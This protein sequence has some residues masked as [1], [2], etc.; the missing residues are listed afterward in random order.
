MLIHRSHLFRS[1]SPLDKKRSNDSKPNVERWVV[2]ESSRALTLPQKNVLAKGLNFA[3][4]PKVIPIPE[5]VAAVEDGLRKADK[6]KASLARVGI[7]GILNKA[8]PPPS[9]LKPDELKAIKELRND[10]SVM[11]LPADKGRATVLL[12]KSQYDLKV[13]TMLS[14]PTTYKKLDRDPVKRIERKLNEILMSLKKS[15]SIPPGLYYKLRSS[16]G[17]TPLF[18]GLPKIHKPGIP[19][20][21]IVSFINSPTYQLSK[22]LVKIISPLVGKTDSHV[23]NSKDFSSFIVEQHLPQET[24]LVSFDVVSLFTSVPVKR[25][26]E[27]AYQR[28]IDD[29]TLEERTILTA[30]EIVRLLEFCLNATYLTYCGEVYQQVFGTAMGSP[31]SVTVANLIMEDIEQRALSTFHSPPSFWKRYVDDV[32]TA[33]PED[34]VLSF[35]EHLNTIEDSI[36]FTFEMEEDHQLAFLDTNITHHSDGSF[37]TSVYRKKTHTDKYLSFDSHHPL[38]H[39][40][41]VA[42][43]LFIRANNIC[44]SPH[45]QKKEKNHIVD[46]LRTNGYPSSVIKMNYSV[47]TSVKSSDNNEPIGTVVLPYIRHVSESIKRILTPLNIRTCFR[48]HQTLKTILVHAKDKVPMSEKRGIVYQIP[49]GSC[50]HT[51]IGQ[52]GRTLEDRLKEHKRAIIPDSTYFTSAVAEHAVKSNHVIDWNNAKVIDSH[53]NLYQRCYLESW[54]IKKRNSSMNRDEGLLPTVYNCLIHNSNYS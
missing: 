11:I 23:K 46:A 6:G 18:Y 48:P 16:A 50:N 8:R 10:N 30:Q 17:K 20:R 42:K 13:R 38:A 19:L 7:I 1:A 44:T 39:K 36:K 2:N 14:N 43:T 40:V 47:S 35:H 52:S 21:P 9:N 32:F 25:A 28:L 26:T 29:S 27:I 12:D 4:S 22:H 49:C 54:Q 53:S 37:S 5:I 24:K 45:D 31:V 3:P 15:G 34:L 33:L 51:Y 41:A